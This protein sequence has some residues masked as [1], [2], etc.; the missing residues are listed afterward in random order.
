MDFEGDGDIDVASNTFDE[1]TILL[2]NDG[3][4]DFAV[5]NLGGEAISG[6]RNAVGIAVGDINADA[7]VDIVVANETGSNVGVHY[8]LG[9]G[10]FEDRQVRYGMRPRVTDVELADLT[11]DGVVDVISPAQVPDGSPTDAA[12]G[13]STGGDAGGVTVL[14]NRLPKCT[15]TGTSGDDTLVGT[16]GSDVI[17]GRGG[18]DVIRGRGGG[19][20]VLGGDG[21]DRLKGGAGVDV[22]DGG[23][24]N[25][26]L[27]GGDGVDQLRGG[28][29]T[30]V[31][32]GNAGRDVV[33]GLDGVIGNDTLGGGGGRDHCR[34]DQGDQLTS[35]P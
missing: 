8:G 20:I 30:D 10:A 6:Y 2:T 14:L 26:N 11:G 13:S 18:N 28:T 21:T 35:C 25:D 17:C 29:G 22:V 3:T 19:D 1:G 12:D 7:I 15:I 31:V 4:G 33:D 16:P 9:D 23:K 5:R 24:G 27:G 34:G 32:H